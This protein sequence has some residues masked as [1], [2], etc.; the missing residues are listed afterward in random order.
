MWFLAGQLPL[1]GNSG[2]NKGE[3][4]FCS[5]TAHQTHGSANFFLKSRGVDILGLQAMWS[6][7]Q[8]LT[9]LIMAESS[10]RHYLSEWVWLCFN[11]V[12][13]T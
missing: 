5:M 9:L 2:P 7:S 11:K 4:R 12:L 10:H 1:S 8:L 3:G 6:L 13:F